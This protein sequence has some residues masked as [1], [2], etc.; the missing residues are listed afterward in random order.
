MP[1]FLL[2]IA[3]CGLRIARAPQFAI[4]QTEFSSPLRS[5]RRR[6]IE[7][8][9]IRNPQCLDAL[10][11]VERRLARLERDVGLLPGG[12]AT[13]EATA[14]RL[15]AHV[16]DR[17]HRVHLHVEDALDRR[18]DLRLRRVAVDAEGQKLTTVLRLLFRDERLLRDD[19]RFDDIPDRSHLFTPP[20]LP[21][22]PLPP[23]P[24]PLRSPTR[25]HSSSSGR[26]RPATARRLRAK[27][28]TSRGRA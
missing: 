6:R 11:V 7:C 22:R 28:L 21:A 16:V 15:L 14:A 17:A 1:I 4:S 27:A 8:L 25:R 5:G 23:R 24:P 10:A 2:R 26:A 19:R 9:S 3:D 13:L 20:P 12:L 18:L